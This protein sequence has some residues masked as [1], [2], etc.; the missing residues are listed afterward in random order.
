MDWRERAYELG[1]LP[2]YNPFNQ[3]G[4][5]ALSLKRQRSEA[6][7]RQVAQRE[8]KKKKILTELYEKYPQDYKK[9]AELYSLEIRRNIKKGRVKKLLKQ[10]GLR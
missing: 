5:K 6:A 10:Y 9:I 4:E 8:D 2:D 3:K 7:L 1:L